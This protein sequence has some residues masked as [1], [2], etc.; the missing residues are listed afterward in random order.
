MATEFTKRESFVKER[1]MKPNQIAWLWIALV[2]ASFLLMY[3]LGEGYFLYIPNRK[4]S[5]PIPPP[6][7]FWIVPIFFLLGTLVFL[8]NPRATAW[9]YSA[10]AAVLLFSGIFAKPAFDWTPGWGQVLLT[11]LIGGLSVYLWL[12]KELSYDPS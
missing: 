2:L 7:P 6:T 4:G 9:V 10:I 3:F 8:Y 12:H 5:P 1:S 11:L